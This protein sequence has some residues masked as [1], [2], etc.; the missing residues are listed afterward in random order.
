MFEVLLEYLFTPNWSILEWQCACR[1]A[2]NKEW[3]TRI[4][5]PA[6]LFLIIFGITPLLFCKYLFPWDFISTMTQHKATFKK[7]QTKFS[8]IV[9]Y[10]LSLLCPNLCWAKVSIF[11]DMRTSPHLTV[12]SLHRDKG[13]LVAWRLLAGSVAGEMAHCTRMPLSPC[14]ALFCWIDTDLPT[15]SS[16]NEDCFSK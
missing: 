6:Y 12:N 11:C 9:A 2:R 15:E 7:F 16:L 1:G 5:L 13:K 8:R 3:S 14:R 10:F 4:L